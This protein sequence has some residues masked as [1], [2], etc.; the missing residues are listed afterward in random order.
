MAGI[1][2]GIGGLLEADSEQGEVPRSEVSDAR[3]DARRA[4]RLERLEQQLAQTRAAESASAPR[5]A[6]QVD[7]E[8]SFKAFA[9][10]LP[11]EVGIAYGPIG[12]RGDIVRLG[13]LQSG[14]AWSTIKVALAAR[15][16][17]DAGGTDQL[18]DT[19]RSLIS[20]AL[21]ESDNAAAMRLWG[22]LSGRYGGAAGAAHAVTGVLAAAG[23]SSTSVSH[24]GRDGFSPYGQTQWSLYGQARFVGA[25]AAGCVPGSS[26][27]LAQMR[28]VVVGQRWGLGEAGSDAFKGGWGPGIGGGYLVRQMGILGDRG[29]ELAVAV[30][31]MPEDGTFATGQSLLAE[32]GEWAVKNLSGSEASGC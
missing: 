18:S 27:L 17:A 29:E 21:R 15:V 13:A 22:E 11:G 24:V 31:A 14:A 4:A 23:D 7:E 30:A 1:A 3:R 16:I 12:I 5:S 25:L 8:G 2:A 6:G 28:Q 9:A 32:L 10:E 19:Q 26:Y 20:S